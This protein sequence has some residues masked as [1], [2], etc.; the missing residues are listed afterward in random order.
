MQQ[1]YK[2]ILQNFSDL[3]KDAY[4]IKSGNCFLQSVDQCGLYGRTYTF[5]MTTDITKAKLF[6][7]LENVNE[8]Q[9]RSGFDVV[10]LDGSKVKIV[11]DTN[12]EAREEHVL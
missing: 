7:N 9:K 12:A 11:E 10:A 8:I 1:K 5:Q 2:A 3:G 6:T 4:V